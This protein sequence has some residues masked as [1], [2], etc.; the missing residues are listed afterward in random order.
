MPPT[1]GVSIIHLIGGVLFYSSLG[2]LAIIAVM[3]VWRAA[4]LAVY[5][6]GVSVYEAY[7]RMRAW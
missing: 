4:M 2:L 5:G 1:V 7:K 6:L 3:V